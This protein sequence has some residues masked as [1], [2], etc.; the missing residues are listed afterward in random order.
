MKTF[1]F[2][3]PEGT[4]QLISDDRVLKQW[5]SAPLSV[6]GK[7]LVDVKY[8][9]TECTLPL[10]VIQGR[11]TSLL[12]RDWFGAL[13]IEVTGVYQ[14][15]QQSTAAILAKHAEVFAEELGACRGPPVSIEVDPNTAPKFFK[16]R[17]VPFA[18]RSKVD[19]AL[20]RLVEQ[21]VFMPVK[22]SRWATPIVPVTK[23]D[24]S[25]RLCGDYRCT[26]NTAVKP[27]VYPLPTVSELFAALAGGTVFTKLDLKQAY[28]QL[29]SQRNY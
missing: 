28:Q 16:S 23:K 9:K 1:H 24:G 15:R 22:H 21:G 18:L 11:G 8:Q 19:E 26:V 27:D 20:D 2:L 13:G 25:L 5:S 4:P 14:V 3:W 17:P 7:V 12:G 29:L 10:L 6:L